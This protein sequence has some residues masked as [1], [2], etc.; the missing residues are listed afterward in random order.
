MEDSRRSSVPLLGAF[1]VG[2][3]MWDGLLAMAGWAG[4]SWAWTAVQCSPVVLLALLVLYGTRL[5][6]R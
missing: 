2:V 1:V 5:H 6:L 3:L 4:V